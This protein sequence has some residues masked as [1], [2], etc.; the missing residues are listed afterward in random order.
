MSEKYKQLKV[1]ELQDILSKK[2]LAQTG[3]KEDLIE[4]LVSFDKRKELEK[5]EKELDLDGFDDKVYP[6]VDLLKESVLSDDED[7][8]LDKPLNDH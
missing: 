2:G 4:R 5:L 8:L 1:K 6:S 3:K 7:L